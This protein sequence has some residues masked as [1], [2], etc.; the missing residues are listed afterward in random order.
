M[1]YTDVEFKSETFRVIQ[2]EH[3]EDLSLDSIQVLA[4]QELEEDE[5]VSRAWLEN[6]EITND[7]E[8]NDITHLNLKES[9][10]GII[11]EDNDL[12]EDYERPNEQ[13]CHELAEL[14]LKRL[15]L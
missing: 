1:K 5:E 4:W 13:H 12:S 3:A 15:N 6:A 8:A 7:E 11:F 10:A 2:V 14:I 9:I